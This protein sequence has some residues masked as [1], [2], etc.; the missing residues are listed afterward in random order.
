MSRHSIFIKWSRYHPDRIMT[1]L[2]GAGDR[3][4]QA[5]S[6]YCIL[7][8]LRRNI[9]PLQATWTALSLMFTTQIWTLMVTP[10]YYYRPVVWFVFFFCFFF[11]LFFVVFFF[12]CF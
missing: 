11:F 1:C 7:I 3:L 5:R 9:R 10:K 8:L 4:H 2:A 12:F 6:W